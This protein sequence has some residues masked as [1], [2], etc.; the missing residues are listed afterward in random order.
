MSNIE[1]M[2]TSA[3]RADIT[4]VL[5]D[6]EELN[7]T[8]LAE[9]VINEMPSSLMVLNNYLQVV[10]VNQGLKD[11]IGTSSDAIL[12]KKMGEII[13]CVHAYECE[14]GC[15]TA[16]ICSECGAFKTVLAAHKN[17][18]R[19]ETDMRI[20]TTNGDS[21]DYKIWA[22]LYSHNNKAYTAI[23]LMDTADKKRRQALEHTFLHDVD[24]TLSVILNYSKMII[25]DKKLDKSA[26]YAEMVNAAA[27]DLKNEIESQRNLIQAE[28]RELPVELS[29]IN[30]MDILDEITLFFSEYEEWQDRTIMIGKH[31]EEFNICTDRSL[32]TRVLVNMTKNALEATSDGGNVFLTC[33]QKD[34]LCVFSVNNPNFMPRSTQLQVFQR[35]FSTK[36][37][38]RGT[39]AYI[40]KLFGEKY[41]KGKVWFTS[42][43]EEGTTFNFSM[44]VDYS[45]VCNSI[46]MAE[47]SLSK[48]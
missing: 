18:A 47:P 14:T 30:S 17:N 19:E 28:S 5:R 32:L 35:S 37:E 6:A 48:H 40:M 24:N 13:N 46:S 9:N 16:E 29:L 33:M 25:D 22:S 34:G 42:N 4:N 11:L 10:F 8:K 43:E 45:D 20:T 38:G 15:G 23:S 3:E 26:C 12:G 1:A 39:G 41:L 21:R 27:K 2:F 44:N 7:G 31:A 36:G